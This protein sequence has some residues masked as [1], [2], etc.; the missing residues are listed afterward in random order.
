[1]KGVDLSRYTDPLTKAD[2]FSRLFW[3]L[4]WLLF[5]RFSPVPFFAWRNFLL[6][7]FGAKLGKRVLVYP[8]ARIW[9]PWNL[10]MDDYSC[11]GKDVDCYCMAKVRLGKHVTVSQYS[12]LCTGTHDIQDPYL[13]LLSFPIT[14]GDGAW[15]TADVFIGP[16]VHIGEGAVVGA[17]SSVYGNVRAWTVVGGNPAKFI[18]RRTLRKKK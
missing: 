11:I 7:L 14:I 13:G 9:A 5:F 18:K 8:S 12:Y 2:K 4:V 3:N 1:M 17:R 6:R 16:G 10:E 15:V